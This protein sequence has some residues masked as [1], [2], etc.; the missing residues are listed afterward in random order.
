M[1]SRFRTLQRRTVAIGMFAVV[2]GVGIG[3]VATGASR[4]PAV[5][6]TA[7]AVQ[8]MCVSCAYDDYG[9]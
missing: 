6:H 8:P 9:I 5:A 4:G 3:A 1:M 2:V 7:G